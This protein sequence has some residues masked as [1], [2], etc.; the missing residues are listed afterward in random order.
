MSISKSEGAGEETA[1]TMSVRNFGESKDNISNGI[2]K[3]AINKQNQERQMMDEKKDVN[4]KRNE[5][6]E[7]QNEK[8]DQDKVTAENTTIQTEES[9]AQQIITD[10]G[11]K[12]QTLEKEIAE[13]TDRLMRR[14]ADFENS[15]KRILKEKDESIKY[16]NQVLLY[17][18][19]SV[20]DDF[21]RAIKSSEES[22][23]YDSFHNGI[24]LIEQQLVSMLE[25]RWS[26]KRFSA[27]GEPFDPQKHEAI[28]LTESET[29]QVPTVVE[30]YQ[31]GYLLNERVLRPAKVKVAQ[32]RV[33]QKPEGNTNNTSGSNNKEN[34]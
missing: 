17:E 6:S 34:K 25:K 8:V 12:V 24:Q 22:K 31:K 18:L 4:G 23:N 21:E 20:I 1:F 13:L 16:A 7:Q 11:E 2:N 30:D 5:S 26:L 10:L 32:P 28:A 33:G 9:Q 3:E 27:V 15:R 14:Q 19:T 29:V